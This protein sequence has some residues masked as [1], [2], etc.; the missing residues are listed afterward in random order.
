MSNSPEVDTDELAELAN[1]RWH[2]DTAYNINC[3]GG[4]GL[5]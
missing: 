4:D 2:W 1:L 5:I 3:A